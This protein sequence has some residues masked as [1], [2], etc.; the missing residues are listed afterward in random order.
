MYSV[1]M[2]ELQTREKIKPKLT[3]PNNFCKSFSPFFSK[4]KIDP[5][6]SWMKNWVKSKSKKNQRK[7]SN[8]RW[9]WKLFHLVRWK[10]FPF[11]IT[12]NFFLPSFCEWEFFSA[13]KSRILTAIHQ[14][15]NFI[16]CWSRKSARKKKLPTIFFIVFEMLN[17]H[18][19]AMEIIKSQRNNVQAKQSR[20]AHFRLWIKR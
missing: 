15:D 19:I 14:K 3:F 4:I 1:N 8:K 12:Q 17:N 7:E 10:I 11:L 18:S 5:N 20:K 13:L 16:F 2:I 6:R 9:K